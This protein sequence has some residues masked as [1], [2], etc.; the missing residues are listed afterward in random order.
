MRFLSSNDARG[1][2]LSRRHAYPSHCEWQAN[3]RSKG[4]KAI[5]VKKQKLKTRHTIESLARD[6][7]EGKR[8]I[9]ARTNER[10]NLLKGQGL[11]GQYEYWLVRLTEN[12]KLTQKEAQDEWQSVT[13]L[14][15]TFG[16]FHYARCVALGLKNAEIW[17]T[18]AGE[19]SADK[20]KLVYYLIIL[21]PEI[22]ENTLRRTIA[23]HTGEKMNVFYFRFWIERA[24]DFLKSF[25]EF[26]EARKREQ[27]EARAFLAAMHVRDERL[28]TRAD[29]TDLT[30][31]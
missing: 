21:N 10:S 17:A 12:P 8:K 18:A 22:S 2:R 29:I 13:G 20:A 25:D 23:A 27:I 9:A 31:E 6:V 15:L 4:Q 14:T 7:R 24:L 5:D 26:S 3:R 30:R 28:G 1:R 11:Q 16:I 19:F